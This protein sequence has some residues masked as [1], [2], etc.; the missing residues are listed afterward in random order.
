MTYFYNLGGLTVQTDEYFYPEGKTQLAAYQTDPVPA[1]DVTYTI[2]TSCMDLQPPTGT[3]VA[4]IN[5]RHWYTL[6][7]GGYAFYDRV[8]DVS[9]QILNLVIADSTFSH[10]E[11][12]FCPSEVLELSPDRRPY[13]L[14]QEALR[15][16]LLFKN[17]TIIHASSLAYHDKGLLF[18]APS[19]TG[20]STHTRLWRRYEPD[21]IIVNDDMPLVRIENDTP[22]LYGAP[23]SGKSVVHQNVRVPLHAIVFLE[24]GTTCTLEP[25]DSIEA[26]WRLFSAVRKPIVP[27]LAEKNLDVISNLIERLPV[28]LLHCDMS[29]DAVRTSMQALEK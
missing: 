13:N 6:P 1:P 15:Y 22:Y 4:E 28:Y 18:S 11:A 12:W 8:E 14:I 16:A 20:K 26:V 25:M 24:R 19:G 5:K 29:E 3:L 21:T 27:A 9:D 17:G 23:W 7:D 10:I 2:H